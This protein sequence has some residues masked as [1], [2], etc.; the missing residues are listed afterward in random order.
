[1]EPADNADAPSALQPSALVWSVL[2]RPLNRVQG[3]EHGAHVRAYLRRCA[4]AI[5]VR[6]NQPERNAATLAAMRAAGYVDWNKFTRHLPGWHDLYRPVPRAYFD[7]LGGSQEALLA[8]VEQDHA[9]YERALQVPLHLHT[10]TLRRMAG[11]YE[12]RRFPDWCHTQARCL[13]YVQ[14]VCAQ[15]SQRACI[16]VPG[17]KTFWVEEAGTQ[18]KETCYPPGVRFTRAQIIFADDGH[19][20]ATMRP[21]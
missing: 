19:D 18:I 1:M 17:L 7:H 21:A 4:E 5:G 20:Q 8:A 6:V 10:W 3:Y 11:F 15:T 13:A 12:L 14:A 16:P 9:A 2:G